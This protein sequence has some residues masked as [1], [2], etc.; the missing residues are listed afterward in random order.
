VRDVDPELLELSLADPVTGL[1]N[2]TALVRRLGA[3]QRGTGGSRPA[4]LALIGVSGLS[5]AEA[6][7]PGTEDAVL[8]ALTSRLAR[9]LRGEDWLARGK[10]GD[11]VVLVDGSIA[12]AEVVASRLVANVGALMTPAGPIEL[13][14]AAGVTGLPSDVDPGEALRRCS[15]ALRSAQLAGAGSVHRYDDAVRIQQD[16]S[17]AL[18]S[19][20]DGALERSEL[21]LV[22]QPVVDLVL[23]RTISVEALLRWRHP[24]FGD[25]P[26]V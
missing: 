24:V 8:R 16:R 4:A 20:L 2:R 13:T 18:R 17:D 5:A 14:A 15:V 23:H 10:D 6:A 9:A 25:V 11:F 3:V 7:D 1:P 26:P 12:D 21:R 19:D 22:F